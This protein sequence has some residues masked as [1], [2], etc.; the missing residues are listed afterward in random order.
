MKGCT[1]EGGGWEAGEGGRGGAPRGR[2]SFMGA[3]WALS[4]GQT[5]LDLFPN[6]PDAMTL[7]M[8]PPILLPLYRLFDL[9]FPIFPIDLLTGYG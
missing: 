7:N 9:H 1:E 3:I 8:P 4:K 5:G 6:L 2:G